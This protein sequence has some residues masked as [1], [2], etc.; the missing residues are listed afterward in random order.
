[1]PLPQALATP[2]AR[3][4]LGWTALRW[5][6][7]LIIAAHGWSRLASG[8]VVPFGAWLNAQGIPFGF[9]VAVFITAIEIVGTI[10]LWIR[11]FVFPLTIIYSIIYITG[12]LM[13][14]S[15]AGW[16]VVGSG[17]NGMEFSVLLIAALLCV[18]IQD[19]GRNRNAER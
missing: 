19:L 10:L 17:R 2:E 1:M 5:T 4:E 16:F 11:R 8:G 7:V 18:G 14:H 12:I 6:L 9:A 15:K 13:I 3:S